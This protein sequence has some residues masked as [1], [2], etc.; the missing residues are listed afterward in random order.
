MK[1]P[2]LLI[3][4]ITISGNLSAQEDTSSTITKT[5]TSSAF[6]NIDTS[7]MFTKKDLYLQKSRS[8]KTTAFVF[9]GI[10]TA[11]II[12]GAMMMG[13]AKNNPPFPL[14][15]TDEKTYD[16]AGLIFLGMLID[17]GSIPFFLSSSKN[18]E[19]AMSFSLKN[20]QISREMIAQV[21]QYSI[22]ALSLNWKF[23][24]R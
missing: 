8:Q 6:A 1:L 19:R 10:G 23:Q 11:T 5:D 20:E 17:L 14:P 16:G 15:P 18:K 7:S 3:F 12:T 4:F 24:G 21:K 13:T 2:Y 22:P 9:L